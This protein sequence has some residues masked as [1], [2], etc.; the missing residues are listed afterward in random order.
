MNKLSRR[1]FL[2]NMAVQTAAISFPLM[3]GG[4]VT[5]CTTSATAI[6][7]TGNHSNQHLLKKGVPV[8]RTPMEP[9]VSDIKSQIA[10][11]SSVKAVYNNG[12]ID[13]TVVRSMIREGIKS[14]GGTSHVEDG[15]SKVFPSYKKGEKIGILI[16]VAHPLRTQPE[17]VV[18]V[19]NELIELGVQPSDIIIWGNIQYASW[20][21]MRY[22]ELMPN[23]EITL[24]TNHDSEAGFDVEHLAEIPSVNLRL[25]FSRILTSQCDYIINIPVIKQHNLCG[26]TGTLKLYYATI[27]LLDALLRRG[28]GVPSRKEINLIEKK[29]HTNNGNPQIAELAANPI[30]RKKT[31]L[32]VGDALLS[33]YDG[34]PFGPPQW[35]NGQI[36]ISQD[37]VSIDYQSFQIIERKRKEKG[38]ESITLWAKYI[39]TAA[40]MRIGTNHPKQMELMDISLG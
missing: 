13:P 28:N 30:L 4:V 19:A 27:P 40:E 3:V 6:K 26:A 21:K 38:L 31:C 1:E 2:E 22:L 9:V 33:M 37:P 5:S 17:V 20:K 32:H 7:I 24:R 23:K 36:L 12:K 16:N 29:I 11:I 34:G 10:K 25:P 39:Q 35:I 8:E 18:G 14:L 15:W